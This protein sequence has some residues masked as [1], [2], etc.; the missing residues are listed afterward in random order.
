MAEKS[1]SSW[2]NDIAYTRGYLNTDSDKD[3]ILSIKEQ[4]STRSF[5]A[6]YT[7]PYD[8]NAKTSVKFATYLGFDEK[9]IEKKY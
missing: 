8:Q 9:Y 3:G 1:V 7:N 5:A 2:F 4:L 6:I